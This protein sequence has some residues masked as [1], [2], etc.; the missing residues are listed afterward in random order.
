MLFSKT[1]G[2]IT[3]EEINLI[4]VERDGDSIVGVAVYS[5]GPH[6]KKVNFEISGAVANSIKQS[7]GPLALAAIKSK[8]GIQ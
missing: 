1:D 2:T 6:Q 5:V 3:A 7:I 4:G 8:E